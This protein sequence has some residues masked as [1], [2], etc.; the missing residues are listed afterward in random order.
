MLNMLLS[1]A[2]KTLHSKMSSA[3]HHSKAT[4]CLGWLQDFKKEQR[5]I[6]RYSVEKLYAFH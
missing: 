4:A 6:G 5:Y 1:V 2:N 3:T